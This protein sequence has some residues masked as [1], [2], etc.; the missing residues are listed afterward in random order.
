MW[1]AGS[2]RSSWTRRER[3]ALPLSLSATLLRAHRLARTRAAGPVLR[4][5]STI[6][7]WQ[8]TAVARRH[9]ARRLTLPLRLRCRRRPHRRRLVRVSLWTLRR[10]CTSLLRR[11]GRGT[12]W[13]SR[14]RNRWSRRR[15]GNGMSRRRGSW[16]RWRNRFH[17]R[18]HSH[19]RGD[20]HS[21]CG[22]RSHRLGRRCRSS[23]WCGRFCRNGCRRRSSGGRRSNWLTQGGLCRSIFRFL[24]GLSLGIGVRFGLRLPLNCCAYFHRDVS[25]NGAGV[26]LLFRYAETGQK[27]NDCFR[28]D[29]E[30]A[31]QLVN[32]D[33]IDISHALLGV[34]LFLLLR[35]ALRFRTLF[36]RF[37]LLPV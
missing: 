24:V 15:S 16:C 28:L 12:Q 26:R 36:R 17:R 1:T 11:C 19:R 27:V 32:S 3:T 33:L 34:C 21:S 7:G 13:L 29:L 5:R 4:K 35:T 2:A 30:F 22:S 6:A 14:L 23:E 9:R 18:W 25:G 20:W 31:G 10:W 8:R 37:C